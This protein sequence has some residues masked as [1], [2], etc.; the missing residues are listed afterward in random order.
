MNC[1]L[2]PP[3]AEEESPEYPQ[4]SKN[5]RNSV[6]PKHVSGTARSEE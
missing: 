3:V 1:G 6:S 4:R 5:A 2:P